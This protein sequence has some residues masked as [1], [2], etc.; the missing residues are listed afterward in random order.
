LTKGGPWLDEAEIL[1]LADRMAADKPEFVI[2][3]QVDAAVGMFRL[4]VDPSEAPVHAV[5]FLLAVVGGVY[6][7]TVWHRVV[8]SFVIQGGDPH[9]DGSG[10]AGWSV[11][12]EITR[13]R[14]T[15]GAL[16]MPK[17]EV[18]DTG[19]CQL[20]VMHSDYRPLDGRYTCYGRVVDG[21]ETVDK[22]RVGDRITSVRIVQ[23]SQASPPKMGVK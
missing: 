23:S 2:E 21:M 11:P 20:F 16:G 15:R 8:P 22:I 3:N 10:D 18:R 12:D 5:S 1:Q 7:E 9:G 6:N 19:G 13:A 14:F 4:S 17:G